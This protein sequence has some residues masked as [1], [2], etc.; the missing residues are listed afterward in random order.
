MAILTTWK[1]VSLIS[2]EAAA[3]TD[4]DLQQCILEDAD[5]AV[6]ED[7]FG[8][9]AD[10]ERAQRYYAA[11]LAAL[12]SAGQGNRSGP[13]SS[14]S[15]GDVSV[16]YGTISVDALNR[17]DETVYGR[18]YNQIVRTCILP[19]AWVKNNP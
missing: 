4:P 13:V 18:C 2:G 17:L 12:F 19:F 14:E 3:I 5:A 1:K 15:I 6:D 10:G 16:G 7:K 11:H 8:S 9:S